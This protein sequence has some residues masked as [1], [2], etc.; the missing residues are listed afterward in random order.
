MQVEHYELLY[1]E[2]SML[3]VLVRDLLDESWLETYR[4]VWLTHKLCIGFCLRYFTI[5]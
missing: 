4:D 2:K 1:L 3:W 5:C